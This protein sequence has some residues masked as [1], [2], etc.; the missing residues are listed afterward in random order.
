MHIYFVSK[1]EPNVSFLERR[2]KLV[3]N[4]TS[5][6]TKPICKPFRFFVETYAQNMQI[7]CNQMFPQRDKLK[8]EKKKERGGG[9]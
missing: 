9:K 4:G 3:P 2:F 5:G 1:Y 8:I 6:T 7:R